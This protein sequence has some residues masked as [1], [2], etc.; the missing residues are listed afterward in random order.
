M[1]NRKK[2]KLAEAEASK[3]RRPPEGITPS[4]LGMKRNTIA[5]NTQSIIELTPQV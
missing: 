4:K 1:E 3:P 5:S 2:E